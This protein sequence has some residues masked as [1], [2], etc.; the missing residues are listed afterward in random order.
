MLIG[1]TIKKLRK[2]RKLSQKQLAKRAGVSQTTISDLERGRNEGT[3]AI[4]GIA[5][6]LGVAVEDVLSGAKMLTSELG[7]AHD[8]RTYRRLPIVGEVQ[9]GPDGYLLELAYP[10][11]HGDGAVDWPTRDPNAYALRVRGDSMHPRYRAGE[12]VIVEPAIEPSPGD[13]VVVCCTDGRKMLK[14]LNWIKEGEVQFLSIN[15]HY[16]PITMQLTEIDSIQLASG[17]APR[18]ALSKR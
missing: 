3:K 8:L 1:Q 16:A 7:E 4:G 14:M 12:F 18:S 13:D 10:V 11:G 5:K 2:E 9:G 17:R 15:N 6:A